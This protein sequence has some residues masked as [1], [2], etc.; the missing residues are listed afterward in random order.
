MFNVR[1]FALFLLTAAVATAQPV[2]APAPQ[3]APAEKAA[4]G[5]GGMIGKSVGVGSTRVKGPPVNPADISAL[6]GADLE[7][8]AKSA[9]TLGANPGAAAKDALL[10]AL[11]LGL[12]PEVA[13]PAI[14]ALALHPESLDVPTLVHYANHLNPSVRDAAITALG[15]YTQKEA[16]DKIIERIGDS[17]QIVRATASMTAAKAKIKAA[18]EPMMVLL[19]RGEEGPAHALAA[20]ADPDLARKIAEQLGKVPDA[21]LAMCLGEIL[22]RADFGPDTARV[23][24]VR[25]I[26][27]IQDPSAVHALVDYLNATPKTDK[28]TAHTEAQGIVT[29]RGGQ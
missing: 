28:S 18:I 25:A 13:A 3:K 19:A 10:E 27:K 29:A 23:E 1:L 12:P 7:L 14:R 17:V 20:M 8:A 9:E 5:A 15:A 6:S 21:T 22:V 26:G 24:V 16:Q 4:K 11:A 2:K